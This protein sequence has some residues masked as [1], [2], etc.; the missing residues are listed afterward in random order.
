MEVIQVFESRRKD[1]GSAGGALALWAAW[2][3]EG[4]HY[5]DDLDQAHTSNPLSHAGHHPHVIDIAHVRWAT[6]TSIT[7]LDLC[8]AV[9]GR[10]CCGWTNPNELDLRDFDP[11]GGRD[12]ITQRRAL[13]PAPALGWVDGALSD[14]RYTE[15]QGARNPLTHSRL[16]R[17]FVLSN[18]RTDFV[19][20]A[21]GTT[22]AARE[23]VVLAKELAQDQ[24]SAFLDVIDR[25]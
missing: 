18:P 12:V 19:V 24:V 14:R 2:A 10:E 8:A 15:I 9:L 22:F 7:S 21:T 23:L 11:A 5:L 6:G 4:L 17:R 16:I 1:R 25:L 20:T 13:L 3:V